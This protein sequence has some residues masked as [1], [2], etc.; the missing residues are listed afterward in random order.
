MKNG[1]SNLDIQG[2]VALD[3][4]EQ[5]TTN[6]GSGKREPVGAALGRAVGRY[7]AGLMAYR[8]NRPTRGAF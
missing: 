2:L 7:Y 4:K 6:G 5:V 1:K 3:S 8:A